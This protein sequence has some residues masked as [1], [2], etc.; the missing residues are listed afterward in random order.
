MPNLWYVIIH[1]PENPSL[2]EKKKKKKYI[3]ESLLTPCSWRADGAYTFSLWFS[4]MSPAAG[5]VLSVKNECFHLCW[6]PPVSARLLSVCKCLSGTQSNARRSS[7]TEGA[8]LHVY[9]SSP[10]SSSSV[11][12]EL[13]HIKNSIW[14]IVAVLNWRRDASS[15]LAKGFLILSAEVKLPSINSTIPR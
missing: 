14:L 1:T 4:D 5:G 3:L 8:R 11:I 13:K 2:K 9:P 15:C 6:R 7:L 10:R 12:A